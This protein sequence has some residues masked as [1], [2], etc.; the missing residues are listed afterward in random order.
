MEEGRKKDPEFGIVKFTTNIMPGM[1]MM[2]KKVVKIWVNNKPIWLK[3]YV[4]RSQRK[5]I[6]G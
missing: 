4:P 3:N 6:K 1:I 5:L 2:N